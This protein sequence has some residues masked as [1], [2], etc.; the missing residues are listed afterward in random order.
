MKHPSFPKQADANS[1]SFPLTDLCAKLDQ[2]RF[3]V[4]PMD[5]SADWSGENQFE[6]LLMLAFHTSMVLFFGTVLRSGETENR[7][8]GRAVSC[9]TSYPSATVP[10]TGSH[11]DA[12]IAFLT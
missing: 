9:R 12:E 5:V 2:L 8:T 6:R 4:I 11:G 1:G 7:R 10:K 3:D